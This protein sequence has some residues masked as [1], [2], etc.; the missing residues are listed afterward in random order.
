MRHAN[1]AKHT[2]ENDIERRGILRESVR[3]GVDLIDGEDDET[4]V[5]AK[6]SEHTR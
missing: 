2:I 6:N 3:E 5:S 1:C 4:A